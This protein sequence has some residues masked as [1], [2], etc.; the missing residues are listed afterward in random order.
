MTSGHR[1][2]AIVIVWMGLGFIAATTI[3][4]S[5]S[6]SSGAAVILY[7]ILAIAGMTST[8]ALALGG[9]A[10]TESQPAPRV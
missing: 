5:A 8:M 7:S 6:M 3:G 2:T 9:T 10:S 1:L 4:L